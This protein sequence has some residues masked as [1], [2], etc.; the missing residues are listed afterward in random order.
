MLKNL[1]SD[2][3]R[4]LCQEEEKKKED[5]TNTPLQFAHILLKSL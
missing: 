5:P 2:E 3:V 4:M 1:N